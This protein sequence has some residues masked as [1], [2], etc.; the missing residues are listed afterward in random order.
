M[1]MAAPDAS[2]LGVSQQ[3]ASGHKTDSAGPQFQRRREVP[4]TSSS[5][6]N[7]TDA[8]EIAGAPLSFGLCHLAPAIDEFIRPGDL[9]GLARIAEITKI[10]VHQIQA[11]EDERYPDL[12][13]PVFLRGFLRAYALCLDLDPDEVVRDY[14]D[15]YDAWS[16]KQI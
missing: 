13:V 10:R 3:T 14:M 5:L 1:M 6:A 9:P 15:A 8:P 2:R 16:R 12:P 11:I 7:A 4:R